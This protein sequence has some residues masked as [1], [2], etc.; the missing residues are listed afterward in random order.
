MQNTIRNIVHHSTLLFCYGTRAEN[1]FKQWDTFVFFSFVPFG[2]HKKVQEK[3][4]KKLQD[5]IW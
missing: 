2:V 5:C 3:K 4:Q 1:L